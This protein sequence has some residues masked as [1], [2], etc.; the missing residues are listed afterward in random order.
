M[1][2]G[3]LIGG[4]VTV[5]V[6]GIGLLAAVGDVLTLAF[7]EDLDPDDDTTHEGA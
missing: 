1:F 7:A 4:V 6:C 2:R 5:A 3:V